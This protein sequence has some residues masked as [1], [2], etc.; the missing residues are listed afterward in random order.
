MTQPSL[1]QRFAAIWNR[2]LKQRVLVVAGISALMVLI[3]LLDLLLGGYLRNFGIHPRDVGSIY[4]IFTS[5][6]VHGGWDHLAGNLPALIILSSLCL[7]DGVAYFIK[8]SLIIIMIEGGL[9]WIFGRDGLHIGA[10]GWIFGLLTLVVTQA[11]YDRSGR[12]IAVAALVAIFY[13]G[14]IWGVLPSQ[15]GVSFEGHLFGAIAGVVAAWMLAK[16]RASYTGG[17]SAGRLKY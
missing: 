10:S 15:S 13:G 9:L 11:F 16:T 4:T 17:N 1:S 2:N 6:F 7:I 14:M 3:Y 8:A 5:P 12:K